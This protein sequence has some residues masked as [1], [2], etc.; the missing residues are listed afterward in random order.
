MDKIT[1]EQ[2]KKGE[3][4]ILFLLLG[5]LAILAI[6]TGLLTNYKNETLT[7]SKSKD[8]CTVEKINLLNVK[9]TKNLVK[10]SDIA[11]V[12]FLKQKVKGNK[13]AKGYSFYLLTF[14][15]KDNNQKEIFKSEYY[16][17]A[18]IDKDIAKL[19]KQMADL[20]SDIVTLKREY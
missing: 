4:S 14:I 20:N 8:I 5:G 1:L 16:E 15:L 7:C 18:D 17:K 2:D 19:R 11:T 12:G 13:Y 9:S 3:H 6:I 10:Y